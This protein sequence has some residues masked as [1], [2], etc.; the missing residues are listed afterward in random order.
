MDD[1]QFFSELLRNRAVNKTVE[2]DEFRR[3]VHGIERV[4]RMT[5]LESVYVGA[6]KKHHQRLVRVPVGEGTDGC[7]RPP[8]ITATSSSTKA[9]P[10][11]GAPSPPRLR[12]ASVSGAME[13]RAVEG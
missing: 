4:A 2:T 12:R 7:G 8:G 6:G 9:V 13:A 5:V 11:G 10:S 3:P 1:P